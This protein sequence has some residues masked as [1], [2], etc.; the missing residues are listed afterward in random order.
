M[1]QQQVTL[2]KQSHIIRIQHVY[3]LS[4]ANDEK[5]LMIQIKYFNL[6]KGLFR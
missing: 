1:T 3:Y 4:F 2:K 6:Q 5:D